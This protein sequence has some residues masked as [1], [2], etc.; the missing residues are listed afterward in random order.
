M[1]VNEMVVDVT[2]KIECENSEMEVR[3]PS[4]KS[5]RSDVKG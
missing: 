3:K 4:Q 1:Q 5:Q 2:T